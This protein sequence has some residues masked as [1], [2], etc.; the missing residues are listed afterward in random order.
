MVAGQSAVAEARRLINRTTIAAGVD[1]PPVDL[2]RL[3]GYLNVRRIVS[4]PLPMQGRV[5]MDNNELVVEVNEKLDT[6]DRQRCIA[7]ELAHIVLESER[8]DIA[9]T[10]GVNVSRSMLR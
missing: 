3:A 6:C 1:Q 5:V 2:D 7:H 4:V 8:M 10:S 9:T